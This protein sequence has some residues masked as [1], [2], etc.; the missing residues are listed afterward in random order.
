MHAKE[1]SFETVLFA[2]LKTRGSS[3]TFFVHHSSLL[4]LLVCLYFPS[5]N[6]HSFPCLTLSAS[7]ILPLSFLFMYI[8]LT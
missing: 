4:S 3:Y 6:F 1:Q 5:S 8:L 7:H 2:I